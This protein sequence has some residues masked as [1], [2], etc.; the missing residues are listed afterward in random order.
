MDIADLKGVAVYCIEIA[1][2]SAKRK[3]AAEDFP[4]AYW[5]ER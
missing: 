3:Q 4:G 1:G 5:F 2:W